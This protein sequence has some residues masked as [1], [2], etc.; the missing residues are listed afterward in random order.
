MNCM[1]FNKLFAELDI[2]NGQSNVQAALPPA[3]QEH[4]AS[5][6][7]CNAMVEDFALI[8]RQARVLRPMEAPSD[9]VW[10]NIQSA[11]IAEGVIHA[12]GTEAAA[13]ERVRTLP[14]PVSR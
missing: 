12:E 13:T 11:L 8:A 4:R 10:N 1:E 3:L 2:S 5:C 7:A 9:R 6:A 14:H